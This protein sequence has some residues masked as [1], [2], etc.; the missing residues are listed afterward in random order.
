MID[1]TNDCMLGNISINNFGLEN[2]T[3]SNRDEV[4]KS[5]ILQLSL[6]DKITSFDN[7]IHLPLGHD[8]PTSPNRLVWENEYTDTL[9][10]VKRGELSYLL[11]SIDYIK[12]ESTIT[13]FTKLNYEVI[14]D[15]EAQDRI[16]MSKVI[17]ET[18]IKTIIP[19]TS[20]VAT[21]ISIPAD[22]YLNQPMKLNDPSDRSGWFNKYDAEGN[23]EEHHELA[24]FLSSLNI[25]LGSDAKKSLAGIDVWGLLDKM[26][27]SFKT[28]AKMIMRSLVLSETIKVNLTKLDS[29]NKG[30]ERYDKLAFDRY[31]PAEED[32]DKHWYQLA[33]EYT[34]TYRDPEELELY[35]LMQGAALLLGNNSLLNLSQFSIAQLINNPVMKPVFV[36]D[37]AS[38]PLKENTNKIEIILK[39]IV[40]EEIFA[41]V[42]GGVYNQLKSIEFL[43]DFPGFKWHKNEV[44][45]GDEYDLR[46][47]LESYVIFN[48]YVLGKIIP[49]YD[50][51]VLLDIG[52]NVTSLDQL[53]AAM[54]NSR[55][56]TASAS[57]IL[58]FMFYPAYLDL[59]VLPSV[60]ADQANYDGKSKNEVFLQFKE[61]Y[62]KFCD[63]ISS[64]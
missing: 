37:N 50:V 35:N 55:P 49:T 3:G 42:A 52:N 19:D 14:F 28:D 29:L 39:S 25:V 48:E 27:V 38:F 4:L 51:Q 30:G 33:T 22:T 24:N 16:L 11:E 40:I 44:A 6:K 62:K 36:I 8:N 41:D 43:Q 63:E 57:D 2:I 13:D 61:D 26:L 64:Y 10:L 46:T 1:D 21:A 7:I 23:I 34:G 15:N 47:F 12:G 5:A 17:S 31:Y 60:T 9:D 58:T 56:F 20:D 53:G 32:K 45:E 59:G 18:I 54:A